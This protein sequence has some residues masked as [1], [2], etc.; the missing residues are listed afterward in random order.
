MSNIQ[1]KEKYKK[2]RPE[3]FSEIIGQDI[4]VSSLKNDIKNETVPTAYGFFGSHGCGKALH[5]DTLIP[6]PNGFI[7]MGN[8]KV[9][10]KIYGSDSSI[11]TVL[12]KYCP[13]DNVSYLITFN[14]GTTLK[15]SSGH[16]W[17]IE[18]FLGNFLPQKT[19][20]TTQEIYDHQEIMRN[21]NLFSI[22]ERIINE[23]K[24]YNYNYLFTE[25][26]F[27]DYKEALEYVDNILSLKSHVINNV[28]GKE[29]FYFLVDE[30]DSEIKKLC[31]VLKLLGGVIEKWSYDG[32]EE[33]YGILWYGF[34]SFI[35]EYLPRIN[36][37][38]VGSCAIDYYESSHV[39]ESV[40][41]ID[42][43]PQD[44][45]CIK[46]DADDELFLC[47]ESFI[48]THN[49]ST[50]RIVS[51][52]LNCENLSDNTE[53][54]NMCDSCLSIEEGNNLDIVYQSM[55]NAGSVDDVRELCKTAFLQ[56]N[57]KKSIYILDEVHNLSRAAFDALLIPLEDYSMPS[58]F[59]LCSTSPE[60]I[61]DTV[62]SRIQTKNFSFVDARTMLNHINNIVD[63]ENI[64]IDD[65]GKKQLVKRGRGSVRD[66]LALLEKYVS[67]GGFSNNA[68]NDFDY[69]KKI[70]RD[71]CTHDSD[72][73]CLVEA[74]N[75][76][77][78]AEK[79]GDLENVVKQLFSVSK[80]Y[81]I[82]L[83][84]KGINKIVLRDNA[85]TF[86]QDLM[87]LCGD[88]L[89]NIRKSNGL[90][91]RLQVDLIIVSIVKK[92]SMDTNVWK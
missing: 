45:Y 34:P 22:K 14:D 56:P 16:L 62:L 9:G 89:N 8:I 74:F 36:D 19:I 79:N 81:I 53:P 87:L 57:G 70:V 48:P 18:Q 21:Y 54:C 15:T 13:Q 91:I 55:A 44:Y 28:P 76:L 5:K 35:H 86:F 84:N 29:Q 68:K 61:P 67:E 78:D 17:E 3:F 72:G 66:T 52:A 40:E 64:E 50:A 59:I 10:D 49:T 6:T 47:T 51:K 11:T 32:F 7:N 33:L 63:K 88:A 58:L 60:K 31:S 90:D 65:S 80:S 26:G 41:P 73:S 71:L 25:Y 43:N 4:I 30:K 12:D 75:T 42:D 82:N 20:M 85:F 24:Y 83:N 37:N 77:N 69:A 39:I 38:I 23:E 46:V 1:Y 27:N 92:H 2:Y